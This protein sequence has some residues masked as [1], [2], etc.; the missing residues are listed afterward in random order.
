MVQLPSNT[1]ELGNCDKSQHR[2]NKETDMSEDRRCTSVRSIV[3]QFPRLLLIT[4]G[5]V[6]THS[7]FNEISGKKSGRAD[8]F[9]AYSAGRNVTERKSSSQP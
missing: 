3:V 7:A 1:A 2:Q 5:I 4:V 6:L 8:A 9:I